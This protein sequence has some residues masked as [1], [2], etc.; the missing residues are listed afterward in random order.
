MQSQKTVNQIK[1]LKH[2]NSIIS[3]I[4][5]R[6][7]F[8][9]SLNTRWPC[10]GRPQAG[11]FYWWFLEIPTLIFSLQQPLTKLTD[12]GNKEKYASN[13]YS[14]LCYISC[15]S[16]LGRVLKQ[17]S[18]INHM[19]SSWYFYLSIEFCIKNIFKVTYYDFYNITFLYII[20]NFYI[21]KIF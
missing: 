13:Y 3:T 4:G 19:I 10:L 7:L 5:L 21:T 16:T 2:R 6:C 18:W 12:A 1:N 11:T 8:N 9:V 14:L 15:S 20:Y 17:K